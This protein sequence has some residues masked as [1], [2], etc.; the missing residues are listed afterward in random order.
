MTYLE[1]INERHFYPN[2][3]EYLEKHIDDGFYIFIN[4]WLERW[5]P[6]FQ[7]RNYLIEEYIN[8]L[9]RRDRI[10]DIIM[11]CEIE[12]KQLFVNKII[13]IDNEFEKNTL[14]LKKCLTQYSGWE[15]ND[16]IMG[17]LC[18]KNM[19]KDENNWYYFR[20]PPI[21]MKEWGITNND[22]L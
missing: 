14:E 12:N 11:Y 3:K 21:R 10:N 18:G 6:M 13:N 17:K 5:R 16:D 8:D 20:V 2:E 1:Y 4:M 22:L 15:N 7:V 19:V 9:E